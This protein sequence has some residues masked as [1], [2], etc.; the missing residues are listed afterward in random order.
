MYKLDNLITLRQASKISGYNPDYLGYLIREGRMNGR[1][2]GR[3]W[4]TTTEDVE[5]YLA[6]LSVLSKAA[7][8]PV[9]FRVAVFVL[10]ISALATFG[11]YYAY[12]SVYQKVYDEAAKKEV[13]ADVRVEKVL[14]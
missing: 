2:V 9:S 11:V 8:K 10:F 13:V 5:Y 1:K 6:N 14:Q 4:M 3:N 7:H 12:A